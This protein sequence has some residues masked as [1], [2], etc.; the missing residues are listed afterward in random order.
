[1]A[2]VTQDSAK[3]SAS[4]MISTVFVTPGFSYV[5]AV[6]RRHAD[7]RGQEARAEQII[8]VPARR[9]ARGVWIEPRPG[10]GR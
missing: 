10:E 6:G 8:A 9:L 2:S 7:G 4:E 1:M 5:L 3:A